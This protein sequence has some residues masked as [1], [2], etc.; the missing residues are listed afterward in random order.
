MKKQL[1]VLCGIFLSTTLLS[2]QKFYTNNFSKEVTELNTSM[3]TVGF[4]T[5]LPSDF[6][7]YDDIVSVIDSKDEGTGDYYTLNFYYNILP[8]A[9]APADG[10]LKYVVESGSSKRSDFTSLLRS[11]MDEAFELYFSK[12]FNRRTFQ[13]QTV[14]V[15][16]MGR[17]QDGMHWVNGEHVPKYNYEELSFSEI[18]LDLG[19]PKTNFKSENG[20]FTYNNYTSGKAIP[21]IHIDEGTDNMSVVYSYG[22]ETTS[23]VTFSIYEIE[24]GEVKQ[25]TFDMSGGAPQASESASVGDMI[26]EIK[27]NVK[28]S[29]IKSSCFNEARSVKLEG[30]RL[31]ESKVSEGIYE[32]Y[33]LDAEKGTVN[34]LK[35]R[36]GGSNKYNNFIDDSA[37]DLPWESKKLAGADFEVL[38]LDLYQYDQCVSS[39]SKK[40]MSVK[41]GE[42]GKTQKTIVF[43]GEV[44]DRLFAGS[45]TKEGSADMNEEDMKFVNHIIST[46]KSNK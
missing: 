20:L 27:L 16:V 30:Q 36:L 1:L 8:V 11:D 45:F 44:N 13:Y 46:F 43:L 31:A 3:K 37:S 4:I 32:P 9:K 10:K 38:E 2:Q 12:D 18:K 15:K 7:K 28:K 29:L 17:T 42:A 5:Q 19:A 39:S 40:S 24:A 41:E 6:K 35:G 25:E 33:M 34:S 21:E 22:D 23:K 14:A 26:E